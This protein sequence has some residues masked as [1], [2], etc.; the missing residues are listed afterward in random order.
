MNDTKILDPNQKR[1]EKCWR[2]VDIWW[3]MLDCRIKQRPTETL[4][5]ILLLFTIQLDEAKIFCFDHYF[6][7]F[8]KKKKRCHEDSNPAKIISKFHQTIS[9]P[10][11][12]PS[13]CR[14]KNKSSFKWS[15]GWF[16]WRK[17]PVELIWNCFKCSKSV[18]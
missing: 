9:H 8:G 12:I 15:V 18:N 3:K 5:W 11:R 1:P 10:S 13:K 14:L 2:S 16:W 6:V 17:E 7:S 4:W